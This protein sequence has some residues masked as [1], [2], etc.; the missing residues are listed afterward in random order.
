[1]S[2]VS[3]LL[4]IVS[5]CILIT[6]HELGHFSMAKLFG[7]YCHEFAIGF[8]PKIFSRKRKDGETVFSIRA[9]PLGGYVSM[10]G[11]GVEEGD[12][13]AIA[14]PKERSLLGIKKWKRAIIMVAGI[15]L[16]F[17][18]GFLL[19]VGN[20]AFF[21]Q[22]FA[23]QQVNVVEKSKAEEA[24]L[25]T[26]DY[27]I[28]I[29]KTFTINGEEKEPIVVDNIDATNLWTEG[30]SYT[31]DL[32]PNSVE[33]KLVF[34]IVFAHQIDGERSNAQIT[35]HG[36][37]VIDKKLFGLLQKKSF[38]WEKMGVG[39]LPEYHRLSFGK[40]IQVASKDWV[41]GCTVIGKTLGGLFIGKNWDQIGGPIAILSSSSQIL[42]M[43]FGQYLYL[44]GLISV[45][46]AIFNLLPFPG[47][48]GWHF[49]VIIFE[50][51]T[52]REMPAKVKNAISFIGTLLL[53]GLM[54]FVTIKDIINIL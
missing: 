17:V 34:D 33:D 54:I 2:L 45:N 18:L 15:F 48:D 14:I 49:V 52:R 32:M 12:E 19:F 23:T 46:L 53:F 35:I 42:Q 16:N 50:S 20:R 1:M 37:E 40:A 8:G 38:A 30:F 7:V 11:E 21:P 25:T 3:I 28:K 4:F 41:D 13:E 39:S 26:G 31:A 51:I 44:W 5:L 27:I 6:I 36:E 47:L 24:G 43:G 9:I 29:T 22:P 10:Y